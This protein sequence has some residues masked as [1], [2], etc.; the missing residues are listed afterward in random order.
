MDPSD[1]SEKNNTPTDVEMRQVIKIHPIAYK[2]NLVLLVFEFLAKMAL[3]LLGMHIFDA[4]ASRSLESNW[5]DEHRDHL[6]FRYLST[7][8][9]AFGFLKIINFLCDFVFCNPMLFGLLDLICELFFYKDM[10]V[11]GEMFNTLVIARCVLLL[12]YAIS[13]MVTAILSIYSFQKKEPCFL[14]EI[15]IKLFQIG[16][17]I[18]CGSI[19][20]I[21]LKSRVIN[22]P[23]QPDYIQMGFFDPTELSS[24]QNGTFQIGEETSSR[25]VGGLN[26]II[27]SADSEYSYSRG[28]GMRQYYWHLYTFTINCTNRNKFYADCFNASSLSIH[29]R[30]LDD[31][32]KYPSYNCLVNTRNASC[33]SKC[34]RLFASGYKLALVKQIDN[35]LVTA[36]VNFSSS[37]V[38]SKVILPRNRAI[39]PCNK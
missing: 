28:F 23:I 17:L 35:R 4:H 6:I 37:K 38:E 15:L 31:G 8:N 11:F 10:L 27:L 29:M 26:D 9:I 24:M 30:Y 39:S 25:F 33:V 20:L 19:I 1:N 16:L 14:F 22:E 34:T 21:R 13:Q 12:L 7:L 3:F 5:L 36:S 2:L 32:I 18:V